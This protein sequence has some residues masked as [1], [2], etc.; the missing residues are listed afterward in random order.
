MSEHTTVEAEKPE[1]PPENAPAKPTLGQRLKKLARIHVGIA[2]PTIL[3]TFLLSMMGYWSFL[4]WFADIPSHFKMQYAVIQLLCLVAVIIQRKP[5]WVLLAALGLGMNAVELSPAFMKE[6]EDPFLAEDKVVG[7]FRVMEMNLLSKNRDYN[8][9]MSAIREMRPDIICLNEVNDNWLKGLQP[10]LKEY[11]HHVEQPDNGGTFGIALYSKI[12][13]I[14]SKIHSFVVGG[15]PSAMAALSFNKNV[16][17]IMSIHPPPPLP[18]MYKHRNEELMAIAD[19][20]MKLG[21]HVVVVG[22]LNTTPYSPTFKNFIEATGLRD[23]RDG[24][25]YQS[26]WPANLLPFRIPIDHIL[27]SDSITVR[28]RKVGPNIGS[29]HLPVVAELELHEP[30]ALPPMPKGMPGGQ[31]ELKPD[32]TGKGEGKAETLPGP[33]HPAGGMHLPD[34]SKKAGPGENASQ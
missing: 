4:E 33:G 30:P 1:T 14:K 34:V 21:Q 29:D 22:D 25:G 27:I 17:T 5:K 7:K 24:F 2:E 28:E 16:V 12:P 13:F 10:I 11:P 3:L 32:A 31:G 6:P 19:S 8:R 15:V 18:G 26:T 23:S 20:R 9:A